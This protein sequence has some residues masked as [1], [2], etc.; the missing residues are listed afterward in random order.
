MAGMADESRGPRRIV[1]EKPFGT[2][3]T[4]AR[5]HLEIHEFLLEQHW[6]TLLLQGGSPLVSTGPWEHRL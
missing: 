5:R 2:D 3:L 1:I 4:S 6:R